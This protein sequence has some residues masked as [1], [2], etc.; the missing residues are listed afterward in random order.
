MLARLQQL[1]TLGLAAAAGGWLVSF[2]PT[3][4]VLG[5]AGFVVIALGYS[6][7]LAIEFIFLK[8]L[9]GA[10]PTPTPSWANVIHAWAGETLTTPR[11]FCWRQPFRVNAIPDSVPGPGAPD[12]P[13]RRGVVFIHGF[14]CNRGLWTPWMQRLQTQG[15]PFV[16]VNLE[17][18]FGGIDNY[19]PI[20]DAAVRR[21]TDA[22]GLAPVLVCHSMGGLAARAWLREGGRGEGDAR[23]HRIITIGTPH[24]GTW[25]GRFSHVTNGRQMQLDSDWLRTLAAGEPPAR[26]ARFTC[27]HSNCDNIVFP[28]STATLPGA[29]NRFV[30]GVAHMALAFCP[31]VM[32]ATLAE[33]DADTP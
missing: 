10:D 12:A 5:L 25:L 4:P 32:E 17:P 27:W 16:A 11:V 22:T 29:D 7:F 18:V 21:L 8:S 19:V 20:V 13:P 31:Q 28:A 24:G 33:I 30:P 1:I 6:L 2:W 3:S 15:R 23:V 14:V 26:A 9:H